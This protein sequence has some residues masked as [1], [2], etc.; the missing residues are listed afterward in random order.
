[1]IC[2]NKLPLLRATFRD[3]CLKL[4]IRESETY[5][6]IFRST[7]DPSKTHDKTIYRIYR[8]ALK[9]LYLGGSLTTQRELIEKFPGPLRVKSEYG[10]EMGFNAKSGAVEVMEFN[11]TENHDGADSSYLINGTQASQGSFSEA[12]DIFQK[13]LKGPSR[14]RVTLPEGLKWKSHSQAG[15]IIFPVSDDKSERIRKAFNHLIKV[16]GGEEAPKEPF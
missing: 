1:M 16:S 2:K 11:I 6:K 12:N 4:G 10:A 13:W 5:N 14:E 8:V 7:W 3:G 9:D 15:C